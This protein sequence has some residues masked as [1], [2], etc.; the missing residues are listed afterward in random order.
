L[1]QLLVV[2][3]QRVLQNIAVVVRVD[4]LAADAPLNIALDVDRALDLRFLNKNSKSIAA[5]Y[6]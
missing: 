5:Q 6:L 1:Q 3:N 4:N 2:R